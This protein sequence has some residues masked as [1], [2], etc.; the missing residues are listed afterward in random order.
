MKILV[1]GGA[2]YVGS[3]A[4]WA[5]RE[6]GHQTLVLDNFSTGH[7]DFVIGDCVEADLADAAATRAVIERFRPDV[8]MHFCASIEVGESVA[9]PAKYYRNNV[10]NALNLLDAMRA[11]GVRGF[12]FSS[13]AAVYGR[14]QRAPL[15]EEHPLNPV[16]PYG[17]TKRIVEQMLSDFHA[18]Y[19]LRFV[20]LRYFNAAGAGTA[21]PLGERH[22]PESHLVPRA[23]RAALGVGPPLDLYGTDYATPDGTCVRDYIHVEDLAAAHVKSLD[24][25]AADGCARAYNLG[26]GRGFSVKEVLTAVERVGKRPVPHRIAPRRAGDAPELAADASKAR[27]ELGWAP[28]FTSLD[29]IVETAWR[30]HVKEMREAGRGGPR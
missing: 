10:G 3:H 11:G 28:R 5:L 16:N 24:A 1:A 22:N 15:D 8:A 23:I 27:R 14:P 19:G 26:I 9:D 30:W 18:A 7:R 20:T 6:A 4:V 12:V 2:G 21:A 25:L 13:S 17:W 29:A